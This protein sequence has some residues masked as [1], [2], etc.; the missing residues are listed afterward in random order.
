MARV[1]IGPKSESVQSPRSEADSSIPGFEH[2]TLD[3]GHGTLDIRHWTL[4]D[5][6]NIA[7][8]SLPASG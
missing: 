3:I 7:E 5:K 6:T 4:D 8:I 1:G 2:M